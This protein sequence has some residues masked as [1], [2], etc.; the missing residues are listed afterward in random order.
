[1][2]YFGGGDITKIKYIDEELT[3]HVCNIYADIVNNNP[4]VKYLVVLVAIVVTNLFGALCI[5]CYKKYE[6]ESKVEELQMT[7]LRQKQS[8][9]LPDNFE[10]EEEEVSINL[11]NQSQTE[12]TKRKTPTKSEDE[13]E[14]D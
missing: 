5:Y 4:Y 9:G 11:D 2:T 6:L 10:F 1:M 12:L 8:T 7:V 14:I 13:G 3:Q